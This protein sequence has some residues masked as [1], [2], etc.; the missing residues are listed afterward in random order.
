MT[1]YV[2]RRPVAEWDDDR[3][4]IEGKTIYENEPVDTG[5]LDK[6]GL[7]IYRAKTPIGFLDRKDT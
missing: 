4:M 2:T 5:L 7:K 6:S 3:P 1:R